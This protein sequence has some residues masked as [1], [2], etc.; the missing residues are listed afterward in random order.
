M[1]EPDSNDVEVLLEAVRDRQVFPRACLKAYEDVA[2]APCD[3]TERIFF[4][5][6]GTVAWAAYALTKRAAESNSHASGKVK[7]R[8]LLS[9]LEKGSVDARR[10]L[11]THVAAAIDHQREKIENINRVAQQQ[12]DRSRRSARQHIEISVRQR[13]P[14]EDNS[15][16]LMP[17][18]SAVGTPPASILPAP[19]AQ[20]V[21][22]QA[23]IASPRTQNAISKADE[24][25]THASIAAFIRLLPSYIAASITRIPHPRE[26]NELVAA[27]TMTYRKS[28]DGYSDYVLGLEIMWNKVQHIAKELFDAHV[29]MEDRNGFRYIYISGTTKVVPTPALYSR[30]AS[31]RML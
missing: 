27:V 10:A 12:P 8:R 6:G 22:G 19:P 29:E 24:V 1:S 4:D 3:S 7:R 18:P 30:A 25:S 11:A 21:E 31:P 28:L 5:N 17:G 23:A 2:K 20:A 16:S 15:D 13:D 14:S 26:V 9:Q